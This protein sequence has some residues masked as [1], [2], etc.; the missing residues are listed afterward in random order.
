VAARSAKFQG[1]PDAATEI[2]GFPRNRSCEVA[3]TGRPAQ[4]VD[5]RD[6]LDTG[7][8]LAQEP[9]P[10]Q[11]PRRR[12]LFLVHRAADGWIGLDLLGEEIARFRGGK[13]GDVRCLR[14]GDAHAES[15]FSL[16]ATELDPEDCGG[17]RVPAPGPLR[18]GFGGD[19]ARILR[20]K[21]V[22][23]L[24]LRGLTPIAGRS[25][26]VPDGAAVLRATP[27]LVFEMPQRSLWLAVRRA[28]SSA[29]PT[30]RWR[31]PTDRGGAPDS[32]RARTG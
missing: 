19:P 1:G 14:G 9:C 4:A 6:P 30:S 15:T 12:I 2:P 31:I 7:M 21:R 29:R 16:Y 11:I 20:G 26:A 18:F 8:L 28:A 17:L 32:A 27:E 24:L 25:R 22:R 10:P 13:F 23:L 3:S 5:M